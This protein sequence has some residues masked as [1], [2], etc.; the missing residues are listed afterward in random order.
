MARPIRVEYPGAIYHITSRG[1]DRREIFNEDEDRLQ[2]VQLLKEGSDFFRVE[3]IAYCLMS[4][5]FHFLL[6]TKEANLSRFM[7]RLNVAYTRYYNYKYKRVGPLMQGRYKAIVVGSDEY[8]LTLSRYIHLN[9]VKIKGVREKSEVEQKII[10][11]KYKWSSYAEVLEPKKRSMYLKCERLLDYTGGDNENGRKEYERYVSEG[12][13]GKTS[14]PME[15]I[16]YQFL[17]GTDKFIEHIKETFIK[18]KE[19]EPLTPQIRG[20]KQKPIE[21]ILAVVAKE[22]GIKEQEILVSRSK[23]KEARQVLIELSYRYC[24]FNK[25]L[26]ELGKELG[27]ISGSGVARVHERLDKRIKEDKHLEGK[28][29]K[30][31]KLICQ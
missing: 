5:H 10:L 13:T 4:N 2:L 24:L 22:Y 27:G 23:H 30:L 3:V 16:K 19:S 1:I 17:L 8:F 25:T 21:K 12:I 7:Q 15:G 14:N 31:A 29:L 11:R 20:I 6:K 26:R 9:P 18:D 28:I